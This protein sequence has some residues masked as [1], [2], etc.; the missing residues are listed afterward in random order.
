MT[1][2]LLDSDRALTL[3][4]ARGRPL[5]RVGLGPG[6]AAGLAAVLIAPR[7][8]AAAA[9]G[10]MLRGVSLTIDRIEPAP[11]ASEAA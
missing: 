8:T 2:D 10:C 3:R 9:I 4:S 1:A 5:L 7:A 6:V 11:P